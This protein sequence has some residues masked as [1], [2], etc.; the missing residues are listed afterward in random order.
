MQKRAAGSSASSQH[1]GGDKVLT[2]RLD[3]K[4][5]TYGKGLAW[6]ATDK[7]G[8]SKWRPNLCVPWEVRG[9]GAIGVC[10]VACGGRHTLLLT[11]DG[12]VFSCGDG[13]NGRL[14]HST[15]H[16][17]SRPERIQAFTGIRVASVCAG[18]AHA[19]ALDEHGHVYT[20]GCG[21]NGR[22]G[23]GNITDCWHPRP[24]SYLILYM[25]VCVCVYNNE[26]CKC[27]FVCLH[28]LSAI[29]GQ[30]ILFS[31]PCS[32]TSFQITRAYTVRNQIM[33]VHCP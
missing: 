2:A 33:N 3:K 4:W 19:M 15:A 24:V 30:A 13:A 5:W 25:Y 28:T 22:L 11:N 7:H 6:G 32:A 27:I 20:W 9:V 29:S 1:G 16:S 21:G 26:L 18:W 10:Q 31:A 23:H 12:A 14:G 8:K 17:H